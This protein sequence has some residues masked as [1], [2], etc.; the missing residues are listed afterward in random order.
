MERYPHIV[1]R[2][3]NLARHY[4]EIKRVRALEARCKEQAAPDRTATEATFI[5]FTF[6]LW[7]G[8]INIYQPGPTKCL[9]L[10]FSTSQCESMSKTAAVNLVSVS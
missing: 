1:S 8:I 9:N 4:T 7:C 10:H 3:A 6:I 5:D 2:I